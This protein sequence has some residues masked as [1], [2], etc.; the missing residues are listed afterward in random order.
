MK[1]LRS[2]ANRRPWWQRRRVWLAFW[3]LLVMVALG[4]AVMRSNKSTLVIYND[5]GVSLPPVKLVAC[6]QT[7][8]ITGQQPDTSQRIRLQ[9]TGN[10]SEIQLEIQAAE[11]VKWEGGVCRP[12]GG[13]RGEIHVRPDFSIEFDHQTSFWQQWRF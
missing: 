7:F 1:R 9:P 11:P 6:Q 10:P 13:Y 12:S 5:T 4:L 8:E 2:R 3:V